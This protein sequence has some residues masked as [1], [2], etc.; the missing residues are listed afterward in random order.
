MNRRGFF[1][2]LAVAPV[3]APAI[4]E[5][6]AKVEP[7]VESIVPSF[8]AT[9]GFIQVGPVNWEGQTMSSVFSQFADQARYVWT[10][11]ADGSCP[12]EIVFYTAP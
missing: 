8:T 1:K 9:S 12:G 3:A 6:L 7:E 4:V 10:I 2:L 5:E 11:N